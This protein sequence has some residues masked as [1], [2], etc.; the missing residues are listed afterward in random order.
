MEQ[1]PSFNISR[2]QEVIK[3]S[4][5]GTRRKSAHFRVGYLRSRGPIRPITGRPSLAP[6]SFTPYP[7]P[8]PC[9]RATTG[10]GDV[11]LTQLPIEK[12]VNGM[13]GTYAPV[14]LIGCRRPTG[15]WGSPTHVPFWSRLVSL[16]SRFAFTELDTALHL[17]STGDRPSLVRLRLE[18]GRAGPLSPGLRTSDYSFARPGR[19]TWTSQGSSGFTPF[20]TSQS[21]LAGR[22]ASKA[23]DFRSR[24]WTLN[25]CDMGIVHAVPGQQV[26]CLGDDAILKLRIVYLG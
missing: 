7:I 3:V 25:V 5:R 13:V 8:L 20:D 4:R 11:G 16:F 24:E 2:G 21:T 19:D 17:R 26:P 12:N 23:R 22:T 6:T 10:V 1:V 15:E 9:G 14:G 18:A